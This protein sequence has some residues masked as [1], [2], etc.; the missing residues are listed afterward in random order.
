[1]IRL[2]LLLL[3]ADVVRRR[4]RSLIAMGMAWCALG[5]F[6]FIDSLDSVTLIPVHGFGW[7]LLIEAT[8]SLLA[9]SAGSGA[10]R[11]LRLFK[12][13]AVAAIGLLMIDSPFHSDVA[14][15]LIIG[16]V[17][18]ADGTLKIVSAR[19]VRFQG[20]RMTQAA[21]A[22]MLLLAIGTLQPL[23]TWYVGTIG[24]NVGLLLALSGL[25]LLYLGQ[26]LRRLPPDA[27][28]SSLLNPARLAWHTADLL[29]REPAGRAEL[30]VHVWTPTGGEPA[31]QRR[32]VIDR[33]IAAVDARG[34]ISTGH[35]ALELAP[36]L[37]ISH[38]PAAEIERS[39]DDFGRMLRATPDNNVP[40]R[41]QPS[42]RKEAADWCEATVHV[43]FA[44][45]DAV[46]LR[47]FWAAYQRD[48]TY[49]L[50]RR[51]CSS[52]VANALDAALEGVLA[53]QVPRWPGFLR[54]IVS[55]EL[56]VAS[57]LR[58]RAET[59]A[60]T[61]G[62]VLDYAR[63]LSGVIEPPPV[64]WLVLLRRARRRRRRARARR[65]AAERRKIAGQSCMSENVTS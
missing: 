29:D 35:A 54:A 62:L 8:A 15:A 17:F 47:A 36:G 49:N 18:T 48:D 32:P 50:T 24:C 21:G 3:G 33:Y 56:W 61:P 2:F 12:G 55:P 52:A 30:V 6:I 31:P 4:W 28:L 13:V 45:F 9:A 63:A 14:L 60:W 7:L 37:Y 19:V 42:Y 5:I 25:K 58:T 34:V 40:G 44:T 11:G 43:R 20:W 1:M 27:P 38:Y 53:Q 57:L 23:P 10:A 26:R 39:P 41:F 46:R 65:I 64:A 22:V 59:M 16:I 51:N